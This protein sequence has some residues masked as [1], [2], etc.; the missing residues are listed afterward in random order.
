MA[1][2]EATYQEVRDNAL[3]TVGLDTKDVGTL[4]FDGAQENA[5]YLHVKGSMQTA[6]HFDNHDI[7]TNSDMATV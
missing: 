7:G 5:V 2:E 1:K 6:R 4:S 3:N